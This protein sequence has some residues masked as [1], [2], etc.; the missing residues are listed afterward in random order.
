MEGV[1]PLRLAYNKGKETNIMARITKKRIVSEQ[2]LARYRTQIATRKVAEALKKQR[3]TQ[4][5]KDLEKYENIFKKEI[6]KIKESYKGLP[7]LQKAQLSKAIKK[8][9]RTYQTLLLPGTQYAATGIESLDK[10]LKALNEIAT[11]DNYSKLLFIKV[12]SLAERHNVLVRELTAWATPVVNDLISYN[13]QLRTNA[14]T[15][16]NMFYQF[17]NGVISQTTL[18]DNILSIIGS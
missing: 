4:A 17:E 3:K 10:F 9:L 2:Q 12:V 5:R 6:T 11:W 1:I 8:N 13:A 7:A 18:E 15:I 16:L 14:E